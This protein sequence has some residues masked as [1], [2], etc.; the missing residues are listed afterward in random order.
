MKIS[1]PE[2]LKKNFL[3]IVKLLQ[4]SVLCSECTALKG[5]TDLGFNTASVL[6]NYI[7]VKKHSATFNCNIF[8][9]EMQ[10]TIST[11]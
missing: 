9:C 4:L 10:L 8:T 3:G 7:T 2:S 1:W 5:P 11:S 6:P